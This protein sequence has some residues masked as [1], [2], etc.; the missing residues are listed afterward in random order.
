MQIMVA[1]TKSEQ[2]ANRLN[3]LLDT[4]NAPAKNLGRARWFH[5]FIKKELKIDVTYEAARKWLSGES[6]PYVKRIGVI[7]KGLNSSVEYLIGEDQNNKK[8]YP[9]IEGVKEACALYSMEDLVLLEKIHQL[10]LADQAR[11]RVIVDALNPDV[12]K[13]TS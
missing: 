4:M 9:P 12:D 6:I 11:L 13:K 10:P 1:Q 3:H 5:D 8:D 2:F 7:A